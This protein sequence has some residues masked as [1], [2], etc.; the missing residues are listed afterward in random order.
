[1]S[2]KLSH[3]KKTADGLQRVVSEKSDASSVTFHSH[4]WTD[5]TSWCEKAIRVVDEVATHND[6]PGGYTEYQ[7][8]N[9]PVVDSYHGHITNEDF[10]ADASGNS[11]RVTVK[12]NDVVKVEQDPHDGTGGDFTIDYAA[13]KITFLAALTDPDVVK[14]TYHYATSSVLTVKPEAGKVLRVEVV[15]VQFS[16]DVE[17]TDTA[18]FQPYGYVD[19]FAPHLTPT[20]YPPGTLIPLGSPVNYKTMRD[21]MNDAFRSYPSYPAMGGAGWRGIP[22]PVLVMDWDYTRAKPLYSAYGMEIRCF[23]EHDTEFGGTY[24]T[25]TFY[26]STEDEE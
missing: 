17:L 7:V 22:V 12:V 21:Y 25:A 24:A 23:L 2:I 8:A 13:G 18:V 15:E 5:K 20:P 10:K 19:V 16:T 9:Y 14:V 11:F 26:C 4:E 6:P 3:V 1:M